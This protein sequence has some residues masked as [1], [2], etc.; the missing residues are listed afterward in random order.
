V[1]QSFAAS[2]GF[3]ESTINFVLLVSFNRI[4]KLVSGTG[5]W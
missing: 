5:L 1:N 4:A 2:I 3:M